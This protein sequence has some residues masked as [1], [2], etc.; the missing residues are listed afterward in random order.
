MSSVLHTPGFWMCLFF[1][2]VQMLYVKMPTNW[3][4]GWTL[5]FIVEPS[6]QHNTAWRD[7]LTHGKLEHVF[8]YHQ[9]SGN[10]EI[11]H[12][13]WKLW[14]TSRIHC[15]TIWVWAVFLIV[16]SYWKLYNT[17]ICKPM[18]WLGSH[19]ELLWL[20]VQF[21]NSKSVFSFTVI[22]ECLV[23]SVTVSGLVIMLENRAALCSAAVS[24]LCWEVSK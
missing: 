7:V 2:T 9:F 23:Q 12:V 19:Y 18:C 15:I 11:I 4:Q 1:C 13:V 10:S 5:T 17:V 16:D 6:G 20:N 22:P 21:S 24:K 14:K 8:V 3:S